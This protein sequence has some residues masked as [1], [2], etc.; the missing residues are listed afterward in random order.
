MAA[1]AV[2]GVGGVGG[3]FVDGGVD[4]AAFEVDGE[5]FDFVF[6][7]GFSIFDWGVGR[8]GIV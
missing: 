8:G 3:V 7:F 2:A 1:G 4:A 5:E 6:D